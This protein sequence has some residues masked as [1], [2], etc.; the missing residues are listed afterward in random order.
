MREVQG[1]FE[2]IQANTDQYPI[3]GCH[4]AGV[5]LCEVLEGLDYCQEE[6][7]CPEEGMLDQACQF[8]PLM[9]AA[10]QAQGPWMFDH[11]LH[12]RS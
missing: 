8:D 9:Q 11:L 6:G 1:H 10:H 2:G 3:F 4:P 12:D 7:K 5:V